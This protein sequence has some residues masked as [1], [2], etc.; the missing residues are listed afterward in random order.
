MSILFIKKQQQELEQYAKHISKLKA[1]CNP[2]PVFG[3]RT[4]L[5]NA[6]HAY[7]RYL[8]STRTNL[9]KIA[10]FIPGTM[11]FKYRI[12]AAKAIDA[13]FDKLKQVEKNIN[14]INKLPPNP[15][16]TR[17]RSAET[18]EQPK[19]YPSPLQSK[20]RAAKDDSAVVK[21]IPTSFRL[22]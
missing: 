1:V 10:S 11:A 16:L 8:L 18:I 19:H 20:K 21:F 4:T 7:G 13:A 2:D 22:N 15:L 14:A 3:T 6:S 12:V 5:E 17:S 9:G